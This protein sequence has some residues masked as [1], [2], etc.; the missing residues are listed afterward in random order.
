MPRKEAT[1][2]RKI[3][4]LFRQLPNSWFE[5]VEQTSING[6]PDILGCVEG[7]MVAIEVK[8]NKGRLSR[9]QLHKLNCIRNAGGLALVL[10]ED[11]YFDWYERILDGKTFI[12]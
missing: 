5:R 8:T 12:N 1:L 9:L 3:L 7:Q 4:E 6:T 2:T 10:N 11:N